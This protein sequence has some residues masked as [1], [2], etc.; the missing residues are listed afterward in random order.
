[1]YNTSPIEIQ[2]DYIAPIAYNLLFKINLNANG[3]YEIT[4]DNNK[5]FKEF[6]AT[7]RIGERIMTKLFYITIYSTNS[8]YTNNELYFKFTDKESLVNDFL[9]V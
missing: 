1:M 7:G 3:T 5:Q 2:Y 4:V 8:Y 6:R 9:P